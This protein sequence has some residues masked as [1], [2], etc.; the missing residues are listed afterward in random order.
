M[1]NHKY[2]SDKRIDNFIFNS[3]E[4]GYTCI[5]IGES[6]DGQTGLESLSEIAGQLKAYS[7]KTNTQF[8]IFDEIDAADEMLPI[9]LSSEDIPDKKKKEHK[10]YLS[11]NGISVLI[12]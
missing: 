11:K 5:L 2:Q 12:Q 10:E 4:A 9:P 6:H 3:V 8:V 1:K 7:E